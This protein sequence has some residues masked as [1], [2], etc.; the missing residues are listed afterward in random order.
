MQARNMVGGLS[1]AKS[2]FLAAI[3]EHPP[4]QWTEFLDQACDGDTVLR[5]AVRKLLDAQAELGTFHESPRSA[6]SDTIDC[7]A[8]DGPGTAI[9]PYRL[10]ERI[11]EGGMGV[12]YMAEQES[13][14]RRRVALKL[15]K[16]GVDSR[17]VLARFEAERQALALMDHANIARVLDAGATDTGRPYFVMEL[18]HGGP[19]TEF[20]DRNRLVPDARLRLFLDVC[21]SI[22]H[23]HHKGVIHRDIKPT[24]VLVTLNDGTP[25]VKVIDFGVVKATEQRLT[26]RTLVTAHGQIIGTPAYMSPEQAESSGLDIDTRSDVYALGVL[27]Y[28]LLTGTTPLV[29]TE[30]GEVGLADLLRLICEKEA[31]RP[32]TRLSSMGE[33][34]T[35]VAGNRGL[36]VR[37]L[38]RLLAG[39][40]DWVVMKALEKDRNRRYDTPASFADDVGRYLRREAVLARPPSLAYRVRKFARRNRT[41]ALTAS[42]VAAALV[43]GAAA[44]TWQAVVATRAQHDALAALAAERKAKDAAQAEDEKTR[45]VLGFVE[46]KVFAAARPEGLE[47]GLGRDVSLGQAVEAALPF[48][49]SS[50]KKQPLVE[51]RLRLTLGIS[52]LHRG[53]PQKA[54]QQFE[55]ARAL[56][57]QHCGPDDPDTLASMN[58]LANSY[59]ALGRQA[60]ALNLREQTLGLRRAKLGADDPDTL[61]SMNNLANSYVAL[62]RGT[63]AL[64]L[65]E[66]TL[67]LRQGKLGPDHP[68]TLVSMHNLACGYATVGR[69]ADA[70]RLHEQALS[71]MKVRLGPDHP[72]TLMGRNS[73]AYCYAALGRPTEAMALFQEALAVQQ[74]KLGPDHPHTLASMNN[75]ACGYEALGRHADALRVREQ[76]LELQQAKLGPDHPETLMSMHNLANSYAALGR[77]ADDLGLREQAL[78]R[79]RAKLGPDHP[80]TLLNLRGM[81]IS[82]VKLDRGAEA[83]PVIDEFVLRE[84]A[85]RAHPSLLPAMFDL[86]LRHF[87][88]AGDAAGCRQTAEMWENLKRTDADSLYDA[89]CMRAVTAAVLRAADRSSAGAEQASAEADRALAS[90]RQAVSTGYRDAAHMTKDHDLDALHDRAGFETLVAEMKRTRD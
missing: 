60:D 53:N 40:L 8:V 43:V 19:I 54:A 32:S 62:G 83:V 87:E 55:A 26:E 86:R 58:N 70:A 84:A 11:G 90:L 63:D 35:I 27:L 77:Q 89:A 3:D 72:I 1:R 13:P 14:V 75:L 41:V 45:L 47:G 65:W 9:G 67:E 29:G 64:R 46:D 34:A 52:F 71:Q 22:Q 25:V 20:C 50:F 24:N 78:P 74:A 7:S 51:A 16:P 36:D 79:M 18:V 49:E 10:L 82:L 28:E 23:A 66:Q 2:I 30:P 80:T 33:A 39:D 88:K 85:T 69:H 57:V 56:Y 42:T 17:Q 5:A 48:V 68:D 37:R 61:A 81:A 4:E 44:A 38:I 6:Q 15:T 12:V 73:L 76:T 31:P 59:A 21:H